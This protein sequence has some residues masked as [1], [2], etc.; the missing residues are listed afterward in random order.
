MLLLSGVANMLLP[1]VSNQKGGL[2]LALTGRSGVGKTTLLRFLGSFIGDPGRCM[3][4]GSSTPN[5]LVNMLKQ[6]QFFMLPVD[7]TLNLDAGQLTLLLSAVSSGM[8]RMRLTGGSGA[9]QEAYTAN[10]TDPFYSSLLITSNY[11]MDAIIGTGD[12]ST[13]QLQFDAARSRLLEVPADVIRLSRVGAD[14]W[15]EAEALIAQN[16]GHAVVAMAAY[17][18]KNQKQITELANRMRVKVEKDLIAASPAEQQALARFWARYIA[19]IGITAVILCERLNVLPW[20]AKAIL[21]KAVEFVQGIHSSSS[22]HRS[23]VAT[24]LWDTLVDNQQGRLP[25]NYSYYKVAIPPTGGWPNW[26]EEG[27]SA[28]QRRRFL[29]QWDTEAAGALLLSNLNIGAPPNVANVLGRPHCWRIVFTSVYGPDDKLLHIERHVDIPLPKLRS[30]IVQTRD[31]PATSWE[32]VY[33]DLTLSGGMVRGVNPSNPSHWGRG[34][35]Q[36]KSPI[37]M[38]RGSKG[39]VKSVVRIAFPPLPPDVLD[40][41]T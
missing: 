21:T 20:N 13:A 38:T 1:V 25:I 40:A 9:T 31:I 35:D 26:N 11:S 28:A 8:E 4:P 34:V 7:D 32:E 19:C 12:M 29:T 14:R 3:I 36:L 33:Y 17:L 15:Y 16:Y 23:D 10:W 30:L 2:L 6:S 5:A 37:D 24:A 27:A 39:V 18:S 41:G 22:A